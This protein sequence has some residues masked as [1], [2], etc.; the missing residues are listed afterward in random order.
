MQCLKN[1]IQIDGCAAPEY[2]YVVDGVAATPSGLY[3]NRD[4]PGITIKL[5]DKVAG[6]NVIT[7][8]GL[9][10]L[11]QERALKRFV[12]RVKTGYRELFSICKI[13]DSF[14]CTNRL[15]LSAPLLYF[16]GSELMME[17]IFSDRI[18][19]YTTIDK[20][21]AA[22]I[23]AYCDSEFPKALKYALETI[24]DGQDHENGDLFSYQEVL[25]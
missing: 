3:I 13:D 4:I 16:L 11:V 6:D 25:P 14:F 24:N 2:N 22:V 9:W 8:L 19:R 18:N 15:E 17:W 12:Q 20:D 23:Q 7:F 5:M 1:Y 10:D 21:R